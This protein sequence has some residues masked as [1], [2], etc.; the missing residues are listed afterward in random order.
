MAGA[1]AATDARTLAAA[2]TVMV[3]IL[4][5][6]SSPLVRSLINLA[7]TQRNGI[8]WPIF[9]SF[10]TT[11]L[12]RATATSRFETAGRIYPLPSE[13]SRRG[14]DRDELAAAHF[15]DGERTLGEAVAA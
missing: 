9:E 14:R 5:I 4:G 15:L 12:L 11:S 1:A 2:S 3:L 10:G 13:A 8:F 6:S 7:F